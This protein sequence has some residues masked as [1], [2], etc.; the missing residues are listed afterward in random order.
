MNYFEERV[1]WLERFICVNFDRKSERFLTKYGKL[2][3][4]ISVADTFSDYDLAELARLDC[5][6]WAG[7]LKVVT[8]RRFFGDMS[9]GRT[10][11]CANYMG[12]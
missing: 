8:I 6:K 7:K 5:L 3:K 2:N 9:A 4:N 1:K 10:D 11:A 12:V